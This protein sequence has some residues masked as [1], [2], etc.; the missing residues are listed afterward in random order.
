MRRAGDLDSG[1]VGADPDDDLDRQLLEEDDAFDRSRPHVLTALGPVAPAA[2]GPALA[3]EHVGLLALATAGGGPDGRHELLAELEDL[4]NSGIRALAVECRGEGLGIL[5][6]LAGR[7][8]PHLVVLAPPSA[9]SARAAGATQSEDAV[10]SLRP[11]LGGLLLDAAG[12][13]AG[14]AISHAAASGL[15]VRIAAAGDAAGATE[16]ARRI[17]TAGIPGSSVSVSGLAPREARVVLEGCRAGVALS[18]DGAGEEWAGAVADL[19]ASGFAGRISIASGI[20]RRGGLLAFGGER[21]LGWTMATVPLL[22][23][24]AGMDALAVRALF[25]ENPARMLA[26]NPEAD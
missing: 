23:M 16:L 24:D 7:V 11:L 4:Y 12:A 19:A 18:A 26:I 10:E 21:G 25:V 20:A 13:E 6:W 3:A 5:H 1:W 14:R 17:E 2:L 15:P 9:H 8:P 22:L